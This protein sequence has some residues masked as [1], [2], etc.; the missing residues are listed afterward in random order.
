MRMSEVSDML[1]RVLFRI[2]T[3]NHKVDPSTDLHMNDSLN[4]SSQISVVDDD[5]RAMLTTRTDG[6]S[7]D[8]LLMISK[9]KIN[10]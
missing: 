5:Q 2:G 4:H 3:R 10:H 9:D 7:G 8:L 1:R 6:D